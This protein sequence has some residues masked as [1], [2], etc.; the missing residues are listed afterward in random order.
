MK[1][2]LSELKAMFGTYVPGR[3]KIKATHKGAT[4]IQGKPHIVCR[5][6]PWG[7]IG[8]RW[9]TWKPTPAHWRQEHRGRHDKVA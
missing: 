9:P 3:P 6:E 1:M 7:E 4:H 8:S 2:S 5:Q